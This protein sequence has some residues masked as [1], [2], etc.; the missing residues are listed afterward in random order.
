MAISFHKEKKREVHLVIL[1]VL[2]VGILVF[3]W[4]KF[5]RVLPEEFEVIQISPLEQKVGRIRI[6]FEKL[7]YQIS[8][9]PQPFYPISFPDLDLGRRDP[10][11]P[12]VNVFVLPEDPIF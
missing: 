11:A 4:F 1:A 12:N 9:T 6:N 8:K 2:L 7:E 10:F 3:F 5:I